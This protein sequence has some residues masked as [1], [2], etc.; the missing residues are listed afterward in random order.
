MTRDESVNDDGEPPTGG[1][2]IDALVDGEIVDTQALRIAL[3]DPAIRDYLVEVLRMR[4]LTREIGPARF[5]VAATPRRQLPRAARWLA[6][7]VILAVGAG[8]GYVYGQTSRDG[9]VAA[10]AVEV[11][12]GNPSAPAAPAPTRVIRFEPGVNWT[13]GNRSH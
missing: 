1:W 7:A 3:D 10:A 12:V 4:Q 5:S 9:A 6:A 8:A 11:V 2:E 13:S